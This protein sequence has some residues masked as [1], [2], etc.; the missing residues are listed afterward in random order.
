MGF[1]LIFIGYF[2]MMNIPIGGVDVLPDAIGCFIMLAGVGK[3]ILHCPENKWFRYSRIALIVFG[4]LA[5]FVLGDQLATAS[6]MMSEPLE[7]YFFG[8]LKS[9]YTLAVGVYHVL[10]FLGIHE[11]SVSVGLP[12]LANRARRMTALTVVYYICEIASFAGLA[13]LIANMAENPDAVLSTINLIIYLIGSAWLLLTWALLLTCYMRICLEGDE[14][15]PY[16]DNPHDQ[17]VS[18]LKSKSKKR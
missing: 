5:L 10:L 4:I 17:I 1:G 3:L 7:K 8:P 2:F 18:Y 13:G 16:R 6:G 11:L 15:M 14:D 9:V 12:K